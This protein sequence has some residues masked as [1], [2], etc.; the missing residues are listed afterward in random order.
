MEK[1]M[2][3]NKIEIE[4]EIINNTG[5]KNQSQIAG[6]IIIAGLVIAGAILLKGNNAPVPTNNEVPITSLAPV[7]KGDRILGN[8]KAKVA[9]VLY[10]DF[11]CPFCGAVYGL[12]EDTEAIKYLKNIDPNWTPFMIGVKEY[13]EAG[14]VQFVYRDWAFL[15]TESTQSAEAARCAGDQEKFWEY[16]DYLYA[17][18]NGENK[19]AFSD[20]NLK[21][22][23]KTLGLE[24]S[25]F[26]KCLDE[27]KYAQAVADSKAEGTKAGVTGTPKGFILKNGK[28]VD[29]IGGAE[30]G[31]T[32]RQKIE[33]ALK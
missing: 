29:T 33:N 16:H 18:Q 22:F 19:G 8:P 5:N 21:A 17:H 31:T 26:D 32:V 28:I 3:E 6:A 20:P 13:A 1:S 15:G 9:L 30:S 24:A 10:G 12:E 27:G 25:A 23:A 2:E 7:G 11:Q 14:D 4:N